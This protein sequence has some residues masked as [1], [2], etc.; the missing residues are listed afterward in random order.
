M[1]LCSFITAIP[2]LYSLYVYISVLTIWGKRELS[3]IVENI[4]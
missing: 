2:E 1:C 3:E 4:R